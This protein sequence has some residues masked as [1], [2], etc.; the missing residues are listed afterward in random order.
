M[1]RGNS[2][3][4]FT[5]KLAFPAAVA[6]L[7]VR[8]S[9]SKRTKF[10]VL[11]ILVL[12][13]AWFAYTGV[14]THRRRVQLERR[15]DNIQ[16]IATAY[17]RCVDDFGPSVV[18]TNL[19]PFLPPGFPLERYELMP[20]RTND[21]DAALLREATPDEQNIRAIAYADGH[22]DLRRE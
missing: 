1:P 3:A 8:R 14:Q 18:L 22:A 11:G 21:R 20:H 6:Q 16:Q 12:V 5:L 4:P 9:M 19:R 2:D 7:F 13:L 17:V 15:L 10:P